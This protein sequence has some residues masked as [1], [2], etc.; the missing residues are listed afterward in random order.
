MIKMA[1]ALFLALFTTAVWAEWA[2]LA[3]DENDQVYF[4]QATIEKNKNI[5][6]ILT[7][8]DSKNPQVIDLA[9]SI[10][11]VKLLEFNCKKKTYHL[12]RLQVYASHMAT[13]EK[14][15]DQQ[16][17]SKTWK[18]VPPKSMLNS[19]LKKACSTK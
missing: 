14:V 15:L 11:Q 17:S 1:L 7:L 5:A 12:T 6:K 2:K 10:S 19:A 8:Y 3:T 13:G 18:E 16:Y 4:D 9:T